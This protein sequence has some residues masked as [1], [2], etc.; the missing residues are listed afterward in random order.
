MKCGA[1]QSQVSSLKQST[2]LKGKLF[3]VKVLFVIDIKFYVEE[4]TNQ[5]VLHLDKKLSL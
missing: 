2:Y 1:W 3:K 4:K 5:N